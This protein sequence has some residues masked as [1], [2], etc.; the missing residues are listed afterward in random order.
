MILSAE[1]GLIEPILVGN[2]TRILAAAGALE[3]D[4][5][6]LAIIAAP[7]PRAAASRAVEMVLAGRAGAI[8]EG[9]IHS[10]ALL[11][12][13]VKKDGG[14]RT[15]SAP[16]PR[17]RPGRARTRRNSLCLGRRNQHCPDL[18]T[19]VDITRNAID[20]ARA[21]GCVGP[22]AQSSPQSRRSI[23][24]FPRPWIRRS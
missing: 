10:D 1:K 13:V 2:V 11:S 22:D 6:D 7:N 5:S 4:I 8:M 20:L 24:T 23:R 16:E 12:E 21:C 18:A 19:K 15:G 3:A 17:L 14:L 9:N